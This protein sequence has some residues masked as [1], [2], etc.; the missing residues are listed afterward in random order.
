MEAAGLMLAAEGGAGLHFFDVAAILVVLAAVFGLI[1]HHVLKLPFTIG[2][3]ASGLAAAVVMIGLEQVFP[4]LGFTAAVRD[5]L[6]KDKFFTEALMHGMLSFLLFAGA[7][8]VNLDDLL[9]H[10]GAILGLASVGVIISTA[11]I[12]FGSHLLLGMLGI[13]IDIKWCLVFGALVS[14]TDPIAVLG[15]MKTAGAPKSLE[16]KVA[17]ESLFND[18]IGVVVF[19]LLLA[20]A[21]PAAEGHGVLEVFLVEVVGGVVLGL[22]AG[23]LVYKAMHSMEEPNLEILLSVALVMG[24]TM[25]AFQVHTSA[26]LACVI[27]GLFIGN[28]GRHFAMG[29]EVRKAL[30]IV[31]SFID[32]LLNAVLFLLVGLEVV[33][34]TKFSGSMAIAAV[35]LIV[36]ALCG[37]FLAVLL[38]VSVMKLK[39]SFSPGAVSILTWGGLK[40]GISVALALSLPE[41]PGRDTILFGTFAIV[42]FSLLVQG[43]TIGKLIAKHSPP[44]TE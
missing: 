13:D 4:A 12:G 37:R 29:E 20:H 34:L 21:N 31:W 18:G 8:H 35:L 7:L 26:P 36:L 5:V 6:T 27:A 40:G 32:E 42:L 30:D 17:G 1:N 3:T 19:T 25:I 38:P 23:W 11:V 44:V 9:K 39:R 16:T 24:V 14:P 2:L 28:H 10:K 33:A 41:F 15:I 22:A 43:L